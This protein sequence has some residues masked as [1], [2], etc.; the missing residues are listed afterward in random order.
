MRLKL[1]GIFLLLICRTRR[2]A[3]KREATVEVAHLDS[4]T[5]AHCDFGWRESSASADGE[6]QEHAI[7]VLRY[8]AAFLLSCGL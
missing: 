8:A 1:H 6:E 2:T 3:R 5:V 7:R 4:R